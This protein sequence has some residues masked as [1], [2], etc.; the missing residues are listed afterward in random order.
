MSHFWSYIN[1]LVFIFYKWIDRPL[2]EKNNSVL[3]LTFFKL[4]I[5][6]ANSL[7]ESLMIYCLF[8][9]FCVTLI[10]YIPPFLSIANK[11]KHIWLKTQTKI[12]SANMMEK[13]MIVARILRFQ[14]NK[15]WL[16]T[17]LTLNWNHRWTFLSASKKKHAAYRFVFYPYTL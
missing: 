4:P 1:V 10:Q 16:K 13:K 12:S 8:F 17:F 11:K 7:F 9:T 3:P 14:R 5:D 6:S 15:I 2:Q